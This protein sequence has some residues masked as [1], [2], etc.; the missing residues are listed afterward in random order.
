MSNG[1]RFLQDA[2]S[3]IKPYSTNFVTTISR[4]AKEEGPSALFRGVAPRVMWI[5]IG[6]AIFLGVYER[7]KQ[8][9]VRTKVL[10]Q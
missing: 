8:I 10:A 6:G 5:S 4:I 9:L 3:T 7:A 1:R 2:S